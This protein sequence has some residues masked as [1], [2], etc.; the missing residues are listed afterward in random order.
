MNP[1]LTAERIGAHTGVDLA[2][3]DVLREAR[4]RRAANTLH[5][6][7][8]QLL[9]HRIDHLRRKAAR[10]PIGN[11]RRKVR[12]EADR[13][14]ALSTAL[15]QA[16]EGRFPHK[17]HPELPTVLERRVARLIND[18]VA[19]GSATRTVEIAA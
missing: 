1:T 10:M 2:D 14:Q 12:A 19:A 4:R 8:E 9:R 18:I 11:G 5:H 13:L 7:E 15:V 17:L 6:G 16:L 3:H